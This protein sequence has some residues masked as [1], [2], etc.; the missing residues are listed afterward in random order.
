MGVQRYRS[1]GA[2]KIYPEGVQ[3]YRSVGASNSGP[4][5]NVQLTDIFPGEATP[6]QAWGSHCLLPPFRP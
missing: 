6:T 1:M 4:H 5:S 3:R 2:S